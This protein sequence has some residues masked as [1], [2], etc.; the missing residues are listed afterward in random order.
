MSGFSIERAHFSPSMLTTTSTKSIVVDGSLISVLLG[1]STAAM[2]D[3]AL[4]LR[5]RGSAECAHVVVWENKTG[6]RHTLQKII[7]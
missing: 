5:P 7:V 6:G 4:N 3:G 2:P 1:D